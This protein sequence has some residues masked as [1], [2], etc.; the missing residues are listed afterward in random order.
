MLEMWMH[1][2]I[3]FGTGVSFGIAVGGGAMFKSVDGRPAQRPFPGERHFKTA[4]AL[5][6]LFF[7]LQSGLTLTGTERGL[8]VWAFL[9]VVMIAAVVVGIL[10]RREANRAMRKRHAEELRALDQKHGSA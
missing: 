1:V 6:A 5:F 8:A 2:A 4:G 7:A 9:A 3:L 10:A